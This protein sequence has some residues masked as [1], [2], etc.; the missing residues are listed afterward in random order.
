MLLHGSSY[1]GGTL[2]NNQEFFNFVKQAHAG[3]TRWQGEDYF[4]AHCVP[5]AEYAVAHYKAL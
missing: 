4:T 3:Q 1:F 5:V 2:V